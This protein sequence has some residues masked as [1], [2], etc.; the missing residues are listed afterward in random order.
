MMRYHIF[1][2]LDLNSILK[3]RLTAMVN[4]ESVQKGNRKINAAEDYILMSETKIW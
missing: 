3:L 1:S 2:I 4:L